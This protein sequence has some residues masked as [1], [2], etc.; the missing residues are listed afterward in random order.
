MKQLMASRGGFIYL[1]WLVKSLFILSLA[2][3]QPVADN[4]ARPIVDYDA[5]RK[6][7]WQQLYPNQATTLY[8]REPVGSR[9]FNIEHVF[10]MSWVTRTL[11]CG[12]RQQCR[13]NSD[14]FNQ[15]EADLHNLFP[16]RT[17]VNAARA[18]FRFAEVRGERRKFGS[19]C[20]FEVDSAAR[21]AEPPKQSRGEIARAMFYMAKRYEL[22][23]FAKSGKILQQW[24]NEDPPDELEKRRNQRIGELQGNLNGYIDDPEQLNRD[25]GNGVFY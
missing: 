25:I 10:P 14:S 6:V 7:F 19:H 3:C 13:A 18:S 4:E 5:A 9:G 24:H 17:D 21:I 2:A 23:I 20:D 8:C 15:I 12:T 16:A 22:S 1:R 11:R